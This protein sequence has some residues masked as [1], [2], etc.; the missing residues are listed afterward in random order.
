M[1]KVRRCFEFY[2]RITCYICDTGKTRYGPSAW[3]R[4]DK[5]YDKEV[6]VP[7]YMT[8]RIKFME[9]A[10]KRAKIE[11]DIEL[12][13]KQIDK[14]KEDIRSYIK[15]NVDW[16]SLTIWGDMIREGIEEFL[17]LAAKKKCASYGGPGTIC[18][19]WE[20]RDLRFWEEIVE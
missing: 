20:M 9:I 19:K 6:I 10:K 3:A 1:A 17:D 11:K 13:Q 16:E 14:M 2:Y 8:E 18:A 15:A 7:E 12:I 5:C 4:M